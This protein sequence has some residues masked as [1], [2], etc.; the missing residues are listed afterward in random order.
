MESKLGMMP[1]YFFNNREFNVYI[2]FIST[3][4][5]L[6]L[7]FYH[8]DLRHIALSFYCFFLLYLET[9]KPSGLE[10]VTRFDNSLSCNLKALP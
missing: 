10:I 3:K 6:L 4:S 1:L 5:F 9:Y 7:F 8:V 2:F